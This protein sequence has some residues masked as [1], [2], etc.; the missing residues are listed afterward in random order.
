ML[1]NEHSDAIFVPQPSRKD[2]HL[3]LA[4]MVLPPAPGD[5][6]IDNEIGRTT[7]RTCA[8]HFL[9]QQVAMLGHHFAD[10]KR[11]SCRSAPCARSAARLQKAGIVRMQ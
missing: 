6:S 2:M 1:R 5:G 8:A 11:A 10:G 4:G 7:D 9:V 3:L